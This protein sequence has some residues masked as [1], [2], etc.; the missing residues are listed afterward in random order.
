MVIVFVMTVFQIEEPPMAVKI[1]VLSIIFTPFYG[2]YL[3]SKEKRISSKVRY[4]YCK[5]C[6][7]IYPVKMKHCP[8]CEE[9]GEKVKLVKYENPYKLELLYKK[10]PHS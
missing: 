3:L 5:E 8:I 4:Y 6:D 10:L 7:Y 1:F 9:K 2:M